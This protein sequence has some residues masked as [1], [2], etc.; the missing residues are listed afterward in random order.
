MDDFEDFPE[1]TEPVMIGAFAGWNDAGDAASAAVEHLELI[2]DARPLAAV[3]PEDYYDYQ[4]NRPIISLTDGVTRKLEWP[5]TQFSVCRPPGSSRDVVLMRGLEPSLRW[6]S[7]CEEILDL[8]RELGVETVVTLGA[9]QTDTPHS[10]PVLVTGSSYDG[11]SA[12]R[13]GLA[14]TRYEGPTG[15]TGVLHDACIQAGVMAVQFWAGVPHYVATPPN[16]PATLALLHRLED[17]LDLPIPVGNLPEQSDAWL[18]NTNAITSDD[19][20]IAEYV[21]SLEE[22]TDEEVDTPS[23]DMIAQDFERYLRRRGPGIDG[24]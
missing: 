16:P 19:A 11:A 7:F 17:V 22:N 24:P 10:R 2:W 13:L 9:L 15:I 23:A 5:S 3:D 6:R 12:Q 21:R 1:L 18:E 4:V 8:V 20:E 14:R